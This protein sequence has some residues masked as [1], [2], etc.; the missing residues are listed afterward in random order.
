MGLLILYFL[1]TFGLLNFI[2]L[3]DMCISAG[4]YLLYFGKIWFYLSNITCFTV[5]S[6]D[7]LTSK[8]FKINKNLIN[9]DKKDI[10][11]SII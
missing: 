6:A 1:F 4:C 7:V 8:V 2:R 5:Q 10:L 11:R 3:W 9:I